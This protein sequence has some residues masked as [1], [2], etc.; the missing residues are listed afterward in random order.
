[1]IS[2]EPN[3]VHDRLLFNVG[4]DWF[5]HLTC[6]DADGKPI[7]LI[8]TS[9]QVEWRLADAAGEVLF[10]K[11]LGNGIEIVPNTT[12]EILI[13]VTHAETADVPA[14][15]YRDQTRITVGD[16][17]NVQARGRVDAVATF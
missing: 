10:T 12:S 17:I 3:N 11:T 5:I 1:M 9:A 4:D 13:T 8:S 7:D 16:I 15:H 6:N 14:G 2:L